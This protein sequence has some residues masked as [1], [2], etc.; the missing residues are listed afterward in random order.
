MAS[1]KFAMHHDSSKNFNS[2]NSNLSIAKES[3]FNQRYSD[4]LRRVKEINKAKQ[5][6]KNNRDNMSTD[7]K[8]Q[9]VKHIKHKVQI[10]ELIEEELAMESAFVRAYQSS[11]LS[12]GTDELGG[13]GMTS[14]IVDL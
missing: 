5:M 11:V 1:V 8:R 7:I 2:V 14:Q 9:L 12:A 13:V 4:Y 6:L 3:H 10:I